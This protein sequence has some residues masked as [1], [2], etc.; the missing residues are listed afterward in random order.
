[1]SKHMI[2]NKQ[3]GSALFFSLIILSLLLAIVFGI[4]T[5]IFLQLQSVARIGESVIALSAAD[6]GIEKTLYDRK[7]YSYPDE[8]PPSSSFT[9]PNGASYQTIIYSPGDPECPSDAA[10]W[11]CVKSIGVFKNTKRGLKVSL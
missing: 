8:L 2:K 5:I 3:K 6:S 4:S 11:F 10:S 7:F 1:M 9:L